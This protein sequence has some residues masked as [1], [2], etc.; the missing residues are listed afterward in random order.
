MLLKDQDSLRLKFSTLNVD[1]CSPS[2]D[3]LGSRRPTQAGVKHCYPLKSDYFTAI[4]S[5]NVKTITDR[6]RHAN[7]HNKQC[8]DKLFIGVNIDDLK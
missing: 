5:C 1:F 7:Y 4:I 8:S 2:H 3:P 6:H